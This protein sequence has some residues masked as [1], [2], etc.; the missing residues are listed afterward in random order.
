MLAIREPALVL[1][2]LS[3][4]FNPG[5]WNAPGVI[6]RTNC[7]AYGFNAP[8]LGWP[9]EQNVRRKRLIGFSD[10]S[11]FL[12]RSNLPQIK[13]ATKAS[14]ALI[15]G[16]LERVRQ[17]QYCPSRRH[18]IALAPLMAHFFRLD[19]DKIWSHKNGSAPATNLDLSKRPITDLET[20][21]FGKY[22]RDMPEEWRAA[23]LQSAIEFSQ[24]VAADEDF[25]E[26]YKQEIAQCMQEF[27]AAYDMGDHGSIQYYALPED[28]VYVMPAEHEAPV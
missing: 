23:T 22:I 27:F 24:A 9:M 13:S 15:F 26:E 4:K 6:R 2:S 12:T 11:L 28:G 3:M 14:L 17:H 7:M 8:H 16:Q 19:G 10:P 25:S 18:I 21:N 20:A 1:P 5:P